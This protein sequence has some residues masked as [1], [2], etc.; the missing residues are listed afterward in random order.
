MDGH[1]D[2][3]ALMCQFTEQGDCVAHVAEI[4]GGHGFIQHEVGGGWGMEIELGQR[5]GECDA[6]LLPH[7]ERC[8]GAIG[9]VVQLHAFDCFIYPAGPAREHVAAEL[10]DFSHGEG[11]GD[12]RALGDVGK[13]LGKLVWRHGVGDVAVDAHQAGGRFN[14]ADDAAEEC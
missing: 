1:D 12:G 3:D 11:G 9:D 7:G 8:V 13:A 10:D 5:S 6:L 2:G 14:C 4:H